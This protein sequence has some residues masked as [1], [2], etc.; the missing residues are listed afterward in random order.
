MALYYQGPGIPVIQINRMRPRPHGG[1]RAGARGASMKAIISLLKCDYPLNMLTF[2]E[3]DIARMD[4]LYHLD[5]YVLPA[6][7]FLDRNVFILH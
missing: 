6:V 7:S 3:H 4:P 2:T 1:R 5:S